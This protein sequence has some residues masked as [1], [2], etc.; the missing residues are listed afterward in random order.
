MTFALWARIANVTRS[1]KLA[2]IGVATLS[3]LILSFLETENQEGY[4]T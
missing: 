4:I 1:P 3:G 2:A